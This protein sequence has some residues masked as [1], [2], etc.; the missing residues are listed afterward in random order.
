MTTVLKLD[1]S[2]Q[3]AVR[4]RA[5]VSILQGEVIV[6]AAEHG[7]VLACDAFRFNSV[8][9]I[10]QLRADAPGTAAQVMIGKVETVAGIATDFDSDWQTITRSFWPGLVTIHLVPQPGL[11]WDLGDSNVLGECAVRIPLAPVLLSLLRASG[12]LAV[13]S[14][15]HAGQPAIRDPGTIPFMQ[16]EVGLVVDQG[17]LPA[18]PASTILR[19]HT[20]G[21]DSGIEMVREGAVTLAELQAVFAK[22]SL[23]TD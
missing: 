8:A 18:G 5:L 15:T 13:A 1:G 21:V 2:N 14:A 9:T 22:I 6:V 12:P 4:D 20:I 7:Y 16:T 17:I 23:A 11:Q 3:E 19:R 10:H